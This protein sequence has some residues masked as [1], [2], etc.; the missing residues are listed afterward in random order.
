MFDIPA[1][2]IWAAGISLLGYFL[3]NE[4]DRIDRILARFGYVML[5]LL[6]I[7]VV[8]VIMRRRRR[9]PEESS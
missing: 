2:A 7:G 8:I 4:L 9:Q 5:L 3:G 1:I 6:I